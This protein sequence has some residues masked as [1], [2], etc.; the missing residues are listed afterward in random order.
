MADEL[1]DDIKQMQRDQVNGVRPTLGV[2]VGV[3]PFFMSYRQTSTSTVTTDE[4]RTVTHRTVFDYVAVPCGGV[5]IMLGLF[6]L[7]RGL[8]ARKLSVAGIGVLAMALGLFQVVR[9]FL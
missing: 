7:V 8:T 9:G 3:V 4:I 2:V 5:A 1:D 6:G